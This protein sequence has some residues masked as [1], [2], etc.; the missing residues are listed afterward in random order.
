MQN[1]LNLIP[2]YTLNTM[3]D[4][5]SKKIPGDTISNN[6]WQHQ[7][8]T[9]INNLQDLVNYLGLDSSLILSDTL[10]KN[11]F[12][13]PIRVPQYYL[14]KIKKSDSNDP[15]LLQVL[16]QISNSSSTSNSIV[17]ISKKTF[18][19]D[20]LQEHLYIKAP[21]LIHKYKNR[22]LITLTSACGIHCRYCFRQ[23]F[24]YQ[25]NIISNKQR[26]L[27]LDYIRNNKNINELILS[28]GDP[29]CVSNKFLDSF[30]EQASQIKHIK[31]IR[32]HSR[33]P[34]VIPDRI[35]DE[36]IQILKK[37]NN[38][39]FVLVTHCNHAQELD[40]YIA[41]KILQLKQINVTVLNQAVLLNKIN[42]NADTLVTLS[43]K[44]FE[45]HI[46]PYYLH[47][48]DP[49]TGAEHYDIT[50]NM[51]KKLMKSIKA[52]LP[53]YLVPRLV[54]EIPGENSKTVI[55]CD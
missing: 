31:T 19:A 27:Q 34:I 2:S 15:L 7:L 5:N 14:N 18:C 32:F 49:V 37:Y 6:T 20:P 51:A 38:F 28:G 36:F 12:N 30:L 46:I 10:D 35:D 53:G 41:S 8:K 25:E 9:T 1:S 13:F 43:K 48:L 29:L 45:C 52:E 55:T 47:L 17:E 3:I 16:P 50:I 44:L 40:D 4:S 39:N 11:N 54:Q 23:N 33:M 26:N 42:N 22:V 21:G 24:P